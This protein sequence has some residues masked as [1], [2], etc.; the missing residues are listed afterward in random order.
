MILDCSEV[1][2]VLFYCLD[3]AVLGLCSYHVDTL[4]G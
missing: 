4:F 1:P 2:A 3:A